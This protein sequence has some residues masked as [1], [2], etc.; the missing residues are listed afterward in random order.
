VLDRGYSIVTTAAG[1]IVADARQAA[2]GDTLTLSFA[3]GSADAQVIRSTP[4]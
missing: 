4:D 1:A 2:A 3:R